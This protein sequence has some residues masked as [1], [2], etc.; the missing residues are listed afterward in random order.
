M[1]TLGDLASLCVCH[2]LQQ[3]NFW[4]RFHADHEGC[5]TLSMLLNR[6]SR[7]SSVRRWHLQIITLYTWSKTSRHIDWLHIEAEASRSLR[8]DRFS[9]GEDLI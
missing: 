3:D 8:A 4:H 1:P 2:V 9:V 7:K 5:R 6:Q